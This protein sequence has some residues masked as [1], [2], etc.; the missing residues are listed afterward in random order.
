MRIRHAPLAPAM[1]GF[2]RSRSSGALMAPLYRLTLLG[3]SPL[4]RAFSRRRAPVGA[5]QFPIP[6]EI[7]VGDLIDAESLA[8]THPSCRPNLGGPLGYRK[9]RQC[10]FGE[11]RG[12]L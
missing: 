11:S 5:Q 8:G 12:I 6:G 3:V 10:R 7:F 2:G 9:K 1:F 4:G